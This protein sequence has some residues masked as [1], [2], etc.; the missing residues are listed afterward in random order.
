MGVSRPTCAKSENSYATWAKPGNSLL[1]CRRT[2]RGPTPPPP[3]ASPVHGTPH[4]ARTATTATLGRKVE[5]T[6]GTRSERAR[7]RD[8]AAA[9]FFLFDRA[10]N[11]SV[12]PQQPPSTPDPIPWHDRAGRFPKR[13]GS[14]GSGTGR[15]SPTRRRGKASGNAWEGGC[16]T[17]EERR[18]PPPASSW[19]R[20]DGEAEAGA[21]H[22]RAPPP[23][24]ASTSPPDPAGP[25]S[26]PVRLLLGGTGASGGRIGHRCERRREATGR[27]SRSRSRSRSR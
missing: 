19:R 25:R 15:R 27:D 18:S 14:S 12:R 2:S 17:G 22:S 6:Q 5:P 3:P 24:T 9:S 11:R 26:G 10:N 21:G 23:L 8:P 4:A 16:G 13:G 7:L 20:R 1:T